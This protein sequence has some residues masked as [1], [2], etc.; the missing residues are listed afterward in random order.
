MSGFYANGEVENGASYAAADMPIVPVN[1]GVIDAT[2]VPAD[3]RVVFEG[4]KRVVS[5]AGSIRKV[6]F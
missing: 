5:F 1:P 3:R 6:S 2:K 4:S